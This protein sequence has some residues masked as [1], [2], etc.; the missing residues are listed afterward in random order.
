MSESGNNIFSNKRE[1]LDDSN[2]SESQLRVLC[3]SSDQEPKHNISKYLKSKN[4]S[5]FHT[6]CLNESN[7]ILEQSRPDIIIAES[8][9]TEPVWSQFIGRTNK[10]YDDLPIIIINNNAQDNSHSKRAVAGAWDQ[11]SPVDIDN[12][13][14]DD[15]IDKVLLKR[16]NKRYEKLLDQKHGYLAELEDHKFQLQEMINKR[17]FELSEAKEML[18]RMQKME[19]LAFLAAGLSHDLQNMN[20]VML[21]AIS[22]LEYTVDNNNIELPGNILSYINLAKQANITSTDLVIKLKGLFEEKQNVFFDFNLVDIINHIVEICRCT[23]PGTITTWACSETNTAYFH[24]DQVCLEQ[25]LLNLCINASHAMTIMREDQLM[26]GHITICLSSCTSSEITKKAKTNCNSFWKVSISD[27]GVGMDDQTIKKIF[28]PMFT[29]KKKGIGTGLG[30]LM[31][32]HIIDMHN[33][34][35]EIESEV[36]KGTTFHLYLPKPHNQQPSLFESNI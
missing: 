34:F 6:Y 20:S 24:G 9:E 7:E 3:I 27:T 12:T 22:S 2:S 35:I 33:G 10:N 29:T 16:K 25:A 4:H 32:Q 5:I 23:L 31:I 18:L 17:D 11:I 8:R 26:G 21:S 14:V 13:R 15:V 1:S 30:L 28:K 36:G 19:S